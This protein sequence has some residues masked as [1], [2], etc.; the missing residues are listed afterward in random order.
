MTM[1]LLAGGVSADPFGLCGASGPSEVR[2][3]LKEGEKLPQ[4]QVRTVLAVSDCS[5]QSWKNSFPPFSPA[6][7]RILTRCCPKPW[8]LWAV[9]QLLFFLA[10]VCISKSC[11]EEQV[12]GLHDF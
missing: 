12:A 6:L 7:G 3:G 8:L 2:A 1:S 11:S 5:V 10:F 4:L 9:V